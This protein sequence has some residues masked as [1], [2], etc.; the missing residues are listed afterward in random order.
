MSFGHLGSLGS[1]FSRL[2][3]SGA[4]AGDVTSPVLSSPD[5]DLITETTAT[6]HVTTNEGNGTL[7]MVITASTTVPLASQI[8][9][10]QDDLGAAATFAANVAVTSTGI[11]SFNI[12]DLTGS[13]QYWFYTT[14]R[15][16]AGNDSNVTDYGPFTTSAAGIGAVTLA[17]DGNGATGLRPSFT[18]S[19]LTAAGAQ[20]D[21]LIKVYTQDSNDPAFT[22]YV[23]SSA[24]IAG[25]L[26][27]DEIAIA[28]VDPLAEDAWQAHARIDRAGSL[29]DISNEVNFT[30]AVPAAPVLVLT[31]GASDNTPDFT[32]TGDLIEGDT[33][34][35]QY[36]TVVTFDSPAS[37]ITNTIDAAE[38]AANALSFA[39]GT[40]AD[41]AWFFRA[42]IERPLYGNSGWSN[43]ET[44]TI[45]TSQ[46][47]SPIGLLLA[48]TKA[49]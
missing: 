6:A 24:L 9:A 30:I 2:G 45:S 19:G 35:F 46:A 10:G 33:V 42:R 8:R 14:Q 49:A 25:D 3:G 27:A 41:G 21:D 34:R 38:D 47:G 26:T 32:L 36:D 18:A 31:S 23:T 7:Y 17:W 20:V 40:L 11:K 16:A 48:L 43:V 12:T 28:G 37:E 1:G 29:G 15:D 5:V 39:T 13:T 22:L 44:I 4:D